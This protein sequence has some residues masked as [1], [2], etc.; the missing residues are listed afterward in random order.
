MRK[1]FKCK[2]C[3]E[4][5]NYEISG[6][7]FYIANIFF[8]VFVFLASCEM[9]CVAG[10]LMGGLI[11]FGWKAIAAFASFA[12]LMWTIKAAKLWLPTDYEQ[13]SS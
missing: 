5:D 1:E 3:G 4:E 12:L 9:G 7:W 6:S 2:K 8:L 11:P 13:P 10:F